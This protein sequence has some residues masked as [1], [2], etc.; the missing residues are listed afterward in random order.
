MAK[1]TPYREKPKIGNYSTRVC[2]SVKRYTLVM[3]GSFL[4]SGILCI[5]RVVEVVQKSVRFQKNRTLFSCNAIHQKRPIIQKSDRFYITS[6]T[7]VLGSAKL[8]KNR[9]I[10]RRPVDFNVWSSRRKSDRSPVNRSFFSELRRP[11]TRDRVVQICHPTTEK[12][13]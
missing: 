4:F 6:T 1:L 11:Y 2:P 3:Q 13:R 5:S 12:T 9:P 10:R 7:L 8:V